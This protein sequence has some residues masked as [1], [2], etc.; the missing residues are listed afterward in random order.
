MSEHNEYTLI[1]NKKR[2]P[3]TKEVYKAYYKQKEREAYLD[4]LAYRNNLS[5]EECAEKGIQTEWQM[6]KSYELIEDKL[7]R[8]LFFMG[9]SE[10][11]FAR[12]LGVSKQAVNKQKQ[13]ILKK[14]KKYIKI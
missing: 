1:V 11:Q 13:R 6:L 2:I 8:A 3:V 4:K 7:I 12:Q 9:M 14:L 10:Q 5:I